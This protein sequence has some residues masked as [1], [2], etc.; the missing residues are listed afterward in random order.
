ME[1]GAHL[2]VAAKGF[3]GSH[4]QRA[5]FD[6]KVFNPNAPSYRGSNLSSTYRRL[7][8]EKQRKYEQHVRDVEMGCFTLLVFSTFGGMSTNSTF[9][10]KRL[11][12]LLAEK[13]DLPY[14]TVM[15]W[16]RCRVSFSL[17]HSAIDCLWGARSS[18]GCMYC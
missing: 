1:D 13:K 18:S 16:L 9:F 3:W 6:V 12:S 14:L 8:R 4:Q 15:S 2:D 10:L 5:F 11:A 17:L 7:E